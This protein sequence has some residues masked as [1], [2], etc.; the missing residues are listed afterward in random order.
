MWSPNSPEDEE[1]G[2]RGGGKGRGRIPVW[3]KTH[4]CHKLHIPIKKRKK[5]KR[6]KAS[7]ISA[8]FPWLK[9]TVSSKK[10]GQPKDFGDILDLKFHQHLFLFFISTDIW[11]NIVPIYFH[12]WKT[13]G[14]CIWTPDK[15]RIQIVDPHTKV[16]SGAPAYNRINYFLYNFVFYTLIFSKFIFYNSK[17]IHSLFIGFTFNTFVFYMVHFLNV[18][19]L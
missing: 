19:F 7:R 16:V 2:G 1:G 18:R 10:K 17:F 4:Y 9:G 13:A 11:N 5:E 14:L 15:C 8:T 3:L 6:K 12:R